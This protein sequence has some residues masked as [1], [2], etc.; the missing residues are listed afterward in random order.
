[1]IIVLQNRSIRLP[2]GDA[3]ASKRVAVRTIYKILLIIY[4]AHL[5]VW[6]INCTRCTLHTSKYIIHVKKNTNICGLHQ[7]T[8]QSLHS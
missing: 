6:I 7:I 1:M 8:L 5:L 2:E 3:D 4:V